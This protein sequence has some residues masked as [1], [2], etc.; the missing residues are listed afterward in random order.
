MVEREL[1]LITVCV[2]V[3]NVDLLLGATASRPNEVYR[4]HFDY[5][6]LRG[7]IDRASSSHLR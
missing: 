5:R 3:G 1:L 7:H 4:C 6:S 2:E